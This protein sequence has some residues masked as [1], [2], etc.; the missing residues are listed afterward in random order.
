MGKS[1]RIRNDR[2]NTTL[3]GVAPRKK[4]GM[5]SWA[6]NLITIVVTVLILASVAISLL[7]SNG[8][9]GRMQTAVKSE[10]FRVDANMMNYYF[11]TQYNSFVSENSSYLSYYGLDT[12]KSLKEQ[13]VNGSDEADGTWFDYMMEQTSAQVEEILVYCEEAYARDIELDD[14]DKAKIDEELEMYKTYASMYGYTTNLYISN[15]YGKGMKL[16]D[17]RNALELST[18]ASKCSEEIGEELEA[19]IADTDID[20][21]YSANKL[22]YDLVDYSSYTFTV[23]YE[24][25]VAEVLGKDNYTDDEAKA[26]EAEIIEAYKKKI[27]TA[28]NN[29]NLLAASANQG[30]FEAFASQFIVEDLFDSNYEAALKDSEVAEADQ[31]S[32]EDETK[33]RDALVALIT[34]NLK[35]GEHFDESSVIVDGKV[36][37][38][39]IT[40]KD[41][42]AELLKDICHDIADSAKDKLQATFTKGAKY[43]DTD[44]ALVWA[45]EEGRKENERKTFEEGDGADGAELATSADELSSFTVKAYLLVTPQYKSETPTRDLGLMV[46][47]T[48]DEAK[49]AIEKLYEGITLEDFEAICDELGGK[50]TDY[51]NYTAGSMGVEAFDTWLYAEDVKVGSFTAEVISLNESSFA[52]AVYYGDGDAEWYVSVKSALFTEKYEALDAEIKDK[53]TVEKKDSVIAKIDG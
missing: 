7:A 1:N 33:I 28:K 47:S 34:E 51:E 8:V 10:H 29:A 21:E 23:K 37:K 13:Y 26:K 46:F 2:A 19:T 44:D 32:D 24:D 35:S 6:L 27:T 49:A 14:D 3:T 17:V 42:Y 11:K 5:P 9:F 18:L 12:G 20:A 25:V 40:V 38:T 22:D 45:F 31:P 30:T 53:Y 16:S 43:S 4:N 39:E 15:M 52:V 41:T 50:F 48:E 36:A